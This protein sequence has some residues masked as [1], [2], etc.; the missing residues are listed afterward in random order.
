[1]K[2]HGVRD[3]VLNTPISFLPVHLQVVGN[4]ILFLYVLCD[5]Q[6]PELV[7]AGQRLCQQAIFPALEQTGHVRVQKG[8]KQEVE[9]SCQ[10]FNSHDFQTPS[11]VSIAR[12]L[13]CGQVQL[14]G[15]L[16]SVD[17]CPPSIANYMEERKTDM[18]REEGKPSSSTVFLFTYL[19]VQV[20]CVFCLHIYRCATYVL[21]PTEARTRVCG[22]LELELEMLVSCMQVLGLELRSSGREASALNC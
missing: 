16:G 12:V 18:A 7:H 8:M 5:E 17:T 13:R 9:N 4:S 11:R 1:M 14:Q 6:N 22:P 21:V 20:Y 15:E 19:C 2:N 10:C 3:L